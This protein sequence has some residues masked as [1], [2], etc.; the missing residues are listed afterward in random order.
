MTVVPI[1]SAAKPTGY[2]VVAAK[3]SAT[4]YIYGPIGASWW[5]DSGVSANQFRKDLDALGN[6]KTIDVR[7]NSDGGDVFD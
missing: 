2:R 4:I 7:I 6:V 3:D 5:S 1:K